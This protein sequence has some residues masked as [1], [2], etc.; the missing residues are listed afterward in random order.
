[1]VNLP[2]LPRGEGTYDVKN[3][4]IR[5]RK[6]IK[7]NGISKSI[8]VTGSSVKEVNRLM[9]EREKELADAAVKESPKPELPKLPKGM[10]HYNYKNDK[11]RYRKRVTFGDV[12]KDLSAT[13]NTIQ[14]VNA[15]MSQKEKEFFQQAK[16]RDIQSTTSTLE[17]KM[18]EWIKL[19]KSEEV[20]SKSYDRIESTFLNH[21]KGTE[22]G[23]MPES[24]VKSDLIQMHLKGRR[25]IKTG[26][27][28]SYSSQ[29]KLYELLSQYFK[30]RYSREPY[31]NPM[32]TVSKPRKSD[33]ELSEELIVW[34]DGEM[35]ALT[36]IALD[37]YIPGKSGFRHG[38]AIAFLM[39]SFMRV[40]E[41]LALKWKDIDFD[42]KTVDINKQLSRVRDRETENEYKSIVKSAKYKSSRKFTLPDMAYDC[43]LA[44]KKTKGDVSPDDYVVDN[45]DGKPIAMNTITNS[46]KAMI[47]AANLPIEKHVTV[48]GLRHSGISYFLRHGIPVEVVSKMAGHKSIQITLDT[49]YS[50][51][52]SQKN[53]AIEEF[54]KK[55]TL[56][57]K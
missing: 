31:L 34:D 24:K 33:E 19:Y 15:L 43:I 21:I 52:E 44:Y 53:S 28:L 6:K 38:L 3:G 9:N 13:G 29:K 26:E 27:P 16:L 50:V 46:Y 41:L 2:T 36:K 54:N 8:S 40:G 10:G 37:P 17:Q 56:R 55:N 25:N 42:N 48:H 7:V 47:K 12:I 20:N 35:I 32:I 5:F 1:M 4:R 30:Y 51:L 45:G 57:F 11:I 39:W 18:A 14:E 22:L 49:Y 23:R